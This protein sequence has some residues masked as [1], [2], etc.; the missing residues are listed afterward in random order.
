MKTRTP[1][2]DDI[3]RVVE[4]KGIEYISIPNLAALYD[5]SSNT[6]RDLIVSLQQTHEVRVLILGERSLR[7][8]FADFRRALLDSVCIS[9]S[10][11]KNAI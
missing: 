4:V 11:T 1:R 2:T 8:N 9:N 5:V 6:I 10:I 3:V 7:V